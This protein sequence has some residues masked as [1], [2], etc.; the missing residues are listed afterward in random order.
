[1]FEIHSKYCDVLETETREQ[2]LAFLRVGYPDAV[3]GRS[4]R[5]YCTLCWENEQDAED[6]DESRIVAV[7][8]VVPL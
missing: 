5:P 1:M 4:A 7:I 6:Q 3:L 8:K 2:A